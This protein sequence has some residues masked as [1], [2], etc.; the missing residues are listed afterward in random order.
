MDVVNNISEPDLKIN[1]LSVLKNS[2]YVNENEK[3][4]I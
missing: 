2:K 1:I 3:Q 4:K